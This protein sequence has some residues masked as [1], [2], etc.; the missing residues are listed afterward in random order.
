MCLITFHVHVYTKY[1]AMNTFVEVTAPDGVA[2]CTWL[3]FSVVA[4]NDVGNSTATEVV[5]TILPGLKL[6]N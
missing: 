2:E 4:M 6:W 1:A 5:D 3:L